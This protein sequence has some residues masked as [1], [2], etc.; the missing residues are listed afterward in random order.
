MGSA[1]SGFGTCRRPMGARDAMSM[2]GTTSPSAPGTRGTG[3][4]A[5]SKILNNHRKYQLNKGQKLLLNLK[6]KL[7]KFDKNPN[8]IKHKQ[9]V[10]T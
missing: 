9:K 3:P 2:A 10:T 4:W 6:D 8:M 5:R 1:E 7:E